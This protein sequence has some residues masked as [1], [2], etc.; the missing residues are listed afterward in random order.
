[1]ADSAEI[2]SFWFGELSVEDWFGGGEAVDREISI[3]FRPVYDLLSTEDAA[4]KRWHATPEG[5]LALILVLDQFPRNLFRGD[6]RSF[7]TDA[8]AL[9]AA[10]DAIERGHDLATPEERRVFFYLPFE[11]SEELADQDRAIELMET[12]TGNP[13]FVDYAQRHRQVIARFGRFPH[14]NAVLGRPST[15]EEAAYLASGGETFGRAG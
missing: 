3:R 10:S 4:R 6:P 9:A 11:H 12:R 5:S 8:M 7:A 1:M 2:L 15:A 14:R 13:T